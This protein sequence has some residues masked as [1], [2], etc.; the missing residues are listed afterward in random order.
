VLHTHTHTY[1]HTHTQRKYQEEMLAQRKGDTSASGSD[2]DGKNLRG[3]DYC[4]LRLTEN[5]VCVHVC[6]RVCVCV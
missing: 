3:E 4:E 2:E 1:P 5:E 6:G